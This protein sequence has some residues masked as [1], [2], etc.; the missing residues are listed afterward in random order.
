MILPRAQNWD[1]SWW[2]KEKIIHNLL[3]S[4]WADHTLMFNSIVYN[5]MILDVA[6]LEYI[7][8]Q[9]P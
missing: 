9:L 7:N 4:Q 5:I 6:K 2:W 8:D 3:K 1:G